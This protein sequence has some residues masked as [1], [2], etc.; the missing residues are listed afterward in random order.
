VLSGS[1]VS[2]LT[3]QFETHTDPTHLWRRDSDLV[4]QSLAKG[5]RDAQEQVGNPL[6]ITGFEACLMAEVDGQFLT[7]PGVGK[8]TASGP[9]SESACASRGQRICLYAAGIAQR[10]SPDIMVL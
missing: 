9:V 8:A 5:L 3:D 4:N 7:D 1:G 10:G 6:D 2:Q